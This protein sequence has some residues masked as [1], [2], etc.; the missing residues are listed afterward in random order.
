MFRT[1][2]IE[3]KLVDYEY[4]MDKMEE[5]E[6]YNFYDSLKYANRSEWEQTR[7][8]MYV[9]AQV[10]SKKKIDIKEIMSFPWED[11]YEE[12]SKEYNE[13]DRNR[14]RQK[15]MMI[16]KLLQQQNGK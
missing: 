10:N 11:D 4:F 13:E 7:L 9:I 1:L 3:L 2:V 15:A 6:V 16:E 14:L 5:W 8:L 12:S